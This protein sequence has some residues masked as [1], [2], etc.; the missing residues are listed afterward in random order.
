MSSSNERKNNISEK[1]EVVMT[2]VSDDETFDESD[3]DLPDIVPSEVTQPSEVNVDVDNKE[4]KKD[5]GEEIN[6]NPIREKLEEKVDETELSDNNTVIVE[7]GSELD[8]N[9][10]DNEDGVPPL[11]PIQ[12]NNN[13]MSELGECP[14]GDECPVKIAMDNNIGPHD[15]RNDPDIRSHI[16]TYHRQLN[17]LFSRKYSLLRGEMDLF[18]FILNASGIINSGFS[19]EAEPDEQENQ[20]CD[21]CETYYDHEEH[22]NYFM[23]CCTK[24]YCLKCVKGLKSE[25]KKCPGCKSN[26]EYL[27]DIK[28]PE[29]KVVA[30][31]D[32]VD[33]II[34]CNPMNTTQYNGKVTLDCKCHLEI[35]ITCAYKSLQDAKHVK[36]GSIQG[37]EG[38]VLP[39]EYMV[40]GACPNCRQVPSNKDDII[41]L[42][43]F[44]PPRY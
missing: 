5:D 34:C 35:C 39:Q 37:I 41:A 3:I 16:D 19:N 21:I 43:G 20:K 42:Y 10:D 23:S 14:F 28:L 30:P 29:K 18:R 33:C 8:D 40:K 25:G 32:A 7:E 2:I 11:E 27:N 1:S 17:F 26:L 9:E 38:I 36:M 13:D 22:S 31:K 4:D 6:Q 12:D 15:V 24:Q 44:L